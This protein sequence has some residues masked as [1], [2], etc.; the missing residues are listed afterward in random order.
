MASSTQV[1]HLEDIDK[2]L[3][4]LIVDG[5]SVAP[6]SLFV[7]IAWKQFTNTLGRRHFED[8]PVEIRDLK[9]HRILV[10]TPLSKYTCCV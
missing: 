10:L 1:F 9:I 6:V 3:R 2:H 8:I 7:V 5:E 4:D